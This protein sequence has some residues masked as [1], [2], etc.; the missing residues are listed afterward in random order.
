M[1]P[2]EDLSLFYFNRHCPSRP[3]ACSV[4]DFKLQCAFSIRSQIL[5]V[6]K[7][8]ISKIFLLQGRKDDVGGAWPIVLGI[9]P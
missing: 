7:A 4:A 3:K 2:F 6:K 5:Q 9:Q 8:G 1:N